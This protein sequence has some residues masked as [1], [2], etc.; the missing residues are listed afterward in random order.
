MMQ[1]ARFAVADQ[2][3]GARRGTATEQPVSSAEPQTG[4]G[5]ALIVLTGQPVTLK[6]L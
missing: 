4:H 1:A 6:P 2:P 5:P 3:A